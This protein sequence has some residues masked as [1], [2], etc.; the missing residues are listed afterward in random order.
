MGIVVI[1]FDAIPTEE[2]IPAYTLNLAVR[3][4]IIFLLGTGIMGAIFGSYFAHGLVVTV[5]PIIFHHRSLE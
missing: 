3:S 2:D 4:L 5:Q 1:I